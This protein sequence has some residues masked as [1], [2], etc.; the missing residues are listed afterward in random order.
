MFSTKTRGGGARGR[1]ERA[2]AR[3]GAAAAAWK[4]RAR[5]HSGVRGDKTDA[6]AH[7]L[8]D[9]AGGHESSFM[10]QHA[11][12]GVLKHAA[13]GCGSGRGGYK[14]WVREGRKRAS[15]SPHITN[16]RSRPSRRRSTSRASRVSPYPTGMPCRSRPHGMCLCHSARVEQFRKSKGAP[17]LYVSG[18]ERALRAALEASPPR[19]DSRAARSGGRRSFHSSRTAVAMVAGI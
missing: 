2:R 13:R 5:S 3:R 8:G 15:M 6:V 1:R 9:L 19:L 18:R 16:V 10:P 17:P 7:A 11:N 14:R 12:R 4:G